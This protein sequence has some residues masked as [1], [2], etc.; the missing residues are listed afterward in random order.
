MDWE[1]GGHHTMPASRIPEGRSMQKP[2]K[3]PS[4]RPIYR[5]K[6]LRRIPPSH[7]KTASAY[8]TPVS[9][10]SPRVL[11]H[12]PEPP[13]T[14]RSLLYNAERPLSDRFLRLQKDLR[15]AGFDF[16][17]DTTIS[18]SSRSYIFD[19]VSSGS[20]RQKASPMGPADCALGP[21][22]RWCA[23]CKGETVAV[24][25]WAAGRKTW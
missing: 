22:L 8:A 14:S 1:E 20:P 19:E 17:A 4:P 15:R 10:Y 12:A 9:S 6:L 2:A 23:Y 18:P 13:V 25:D 3:V 24:R 16:E 7:R 5:P 21:T 11:F